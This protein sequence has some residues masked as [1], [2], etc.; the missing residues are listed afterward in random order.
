MRLQMASPVYYRQI[1]GLDYEIAY[2][3]K[4]IGEYVEEIEYGSNDLIISIEPI[5]VP[6][7]ILEFG[8][9]RER[10]K[11]ESYVNRILVDKYID[12]ERYVRGDFEE[13]KKLMIGNILRSVKSIKGKCNINYDDFEKD[14]LNKFKYTQEEIKP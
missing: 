6:L 10:T 3:C 14:I 12:Y 4:E 9:W 1:Y 13:R 8:F 5:I 11:M 2:M 7:G